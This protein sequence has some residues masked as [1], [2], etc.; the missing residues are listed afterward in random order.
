MIVA[1]CPT[2]T[3]AMSASA[4]LVVTTYDETSAMVTKAEL[5]S[6]SSTRVA[7]GAAG[8][9]PDLAGDRGHEAAIGA[10]R[11]AFA[12]FALA[13]LY[14]ARACATCCLAWLIC[15]TWAP[16]CAWAAASSW[17]A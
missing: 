7:S 11:A 2:V 8:R 1:A 14:V 4:M 5:R 12:R 15:E 9:S 10:V 3:L 17:L 13:S 16:G 6:S